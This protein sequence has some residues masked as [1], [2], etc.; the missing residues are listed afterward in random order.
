M[1]PTPATYTWNI[2][3]PPPDLTAPDTFLDSA[4]DSIT[5]STSATFTFSSDDPTATFEC[6]VD[7]STFTACASP[8]ALSGLAAG[9]HEFVVQARDPAGN[10]DSTPVTFLWSISSTPVPTTV[11]CGQVITQSIKLRN[12][13]IDCLWDGI[14][15]GAP[16]IT[17]DLDG[18]TVDGKGVAA[19]IRNDG[20]DF[21]SIKNGIVTDFDYG[22]MLNP[23]TTNNIIE[24]MTLQANQEAGVGLGFLPHPLDPILPFPEPPPPTFQAGLRDNI[25]RNSTILANDTGIWLVHSTRG[26]LISGNEINANGKGGVL[27]ESSNDNRVENNQIS[28]S[29]EPGVALVGSNNNTILNNMLTEN[30]GGVYLTLTDSLA[31]YRPSNNNLVQGNIITESGGPGIDLAGSTNGALT[32]NQIL[33]NVATFSNGEALSLYH[34]N[35]TLI[36]GNDL[37]GNKAGIELKNSSSNRIESNDT[38][39]SE[40]TGISV[41]DLSESNQVV[42]NIS[43][44]NIGTGIYVGDEVAGSSGSLIEGNQT[45]NNDSYG[46]HV[47]KPSHIVKNNSANENATWGIYLGD[48]SN[49][50]Y[51]VDGGGNRGQGNLGPIDPFTL[52]PLQCYNVLCTGGDAPPDPIPPDT[53]ILQGPP[54]PSLTSSATFHFS[55]SDNVGSVTFE[56]RLDTGTFGSCVSPVTMTV[57]AGAH[58]FE[59]RSVDLSGNVDTTPAA[60][61]WTAMFTAGA[62]DTTIVSGPDLTSVQTNA[63]FQFSS[64]EAGSTFACSLDGSA[65]VICTSPISYAPLAIGSHTFSVYAINSGGDADLTPAT[66]TWQIGSAPVAAEVGC[67]EIIVRSTR[68]LNDLIDCGGHGL[69]IGAN[70]I[71]I[72]LDGH[73]IDGVG[74]D[75]GILNNGYDSVTITN[76]TI[77]QFDY[78]ML[79]NPGTSLNIIDSM[80]LE[81]NQEA[82][83]LLSDA[84][85]AGKGNIIRNNTFA[86]NGAGIW[87]ASNTRFTSIYDNALG[88]NAGDGVLIEFSSDNRIERNEIS[89]SGGSG[90]LMLGGGNNIV[91]DNNLLDNG[92]FGIGVGEEL[93]PSNN[94]LIERNTVTGGQGGVLVADST[95]NQILFNSI[96]ATFGP[97]VS[98]EL[99][100]NNL[101]RGNDVRSNASGIS[102]DESND[103][104]IEANNASGTMGTG[105]EIGALSYRNTVVQNAA[106]Q[107]GGEGITIEDFALSGQGNLLDRNTADG[108]G[109][110]GIG[111]HGV[112]HTVTSNTAQM[113]GGWGIYIAVSATDGGGNLAAGN[114]E[115]AQCFN[116]ACS[117]GTVPGSPETWIVSGPVDVNPGTPGIQSNSRNASFTYMG[118]DN[119]TPLIE[120]VF[121][122]RL[123]TTNDLAWEDCEYPAE[124]LNLSPGPHVFEIRTVDMQGAGLAD[125]TPARFEWT[126]VPLPTGVAPVVTLDIVPENPSV[127][128]EA[129]FTFHANEPDVTFE[130]RVDFFG[131]EPCGFEGAT[132]MSQGGYEAAFEETE[133]GNHTFYV[134]AIDFEGNVGTPTTYTWSILGIVTTFTDGPGF[135]PG[136]TP[137]DPPTGG[138][139]AET[140]AILNFIAN[141][142]DA[143]YECSLDL[144]PFLPCVR[145]LSRTR[146]LSR[147][148]ICCES[149][150]L[151][152]RPVQKNL[153]RQNTNGRSSNS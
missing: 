137:F 60:H 101:V 132:F 43:S 83:L 98:L 78:G 131:Y 125:P 54:H 126:Y 12:D 51:S 66:Y 110:D 64:S 39:N 94:N 56:C 70:G 117:I 20:Y 107:N 81:S 89:R 119:A 129:L 149:S 38:S 133:V 143:T 144:E 47:P 93:L 63:T 23:G 90:I 8:L 145:H 104:R 7:D 105:I 151:I 96:T 147:A 106:N 40:G 71:T 109:G 123:D 22:V 52:K 58:T 113:N 5:V 27:M 15:I 103:N 26:T 53:L 24:N 112:G 31:G 36:R 135:T 114:A 84:D 92:G 72:D 128:F 17:I 142:A 152:W 87:L 2:V 111:V 62:P 11:F 10:I 134:R 42:G 55:G 86:A 124:F 29:S 49:G 30:G 77:T 16:G 100:H 140:T 108:N 85:Q 61:T 59:V 68:L 6:S 118:S 1:D 25:I 116:I 14:V 45:H 41:S 127:L 73:L 44:D 35:N 153:K 18:H 138:P 69:I 141:V 19:G 115:P 136:E 80:R 75:A 33:D 150:R 130:C 32:G 88:G 82:G 57:S 122:C 99:S 28:A 102:V 74:L 3:L 21:V 91:T 34:S 13:L 50:R 9:A 95:N 146:T 121:E 67:G 65:P 4:P 48:P 46:I 120:L 76:G 37:R 139:V 97:G 79:L 148:I